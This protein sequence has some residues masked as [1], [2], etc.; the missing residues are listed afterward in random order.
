MLNF[1]NKKVLVSISILFVIVL[2]VLVILN[3]ISKQNSNK[4]NSN[5]E[6]SA[7]DI[8]TILTNYNIIPNNYSNKRDITIPKNSVWLH[9]VNNKKRLKYYLDKYVGFEIDIQFNAEKNYFNVDHDS[10]KKGENLADMLKDIP[11]L[12]T[13]YLWFDFKNLSQDNKFISLQNLNKIV[14]DNKLIK[15]YIVVENNNPDA[16]DV[17]KQAGYYTSFYLSCYSWNNLATIKDFLYKDIKKLEESDVD[18]VSSDAKYFDIVRFC[19]PK[20]AHLF[21][22][23]KDEQ[24]Q[25][26]KTDNIFET[27][28]NAYVVLNDDTGKYYK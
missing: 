5:T 28:E 9:R 17:F 21:W 12:E 22:V 11:G 23:I 24:N 10:S 27:D 1:I 8:E 18:F 19:F 26:L 4:K 2:S 7:A 25:Q 15:E 6:I 3:I 14:E 16:L 20:V 13:K